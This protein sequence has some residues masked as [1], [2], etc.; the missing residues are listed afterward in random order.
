MHR[1]DVAR[2]M[3]RQ[4]AEHLKHKRNERSIK[5]QLTLLEKRPGG[6][7]KEKARLLKLLNKST[8]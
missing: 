8:S 6:S 4:K 3:R 7:T 5:E 2:E 1:G